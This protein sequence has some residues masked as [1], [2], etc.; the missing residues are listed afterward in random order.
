LEKFA[1][2]RYRQEVVLAVSRRLG[3]R[4]ELQVR[5]KLRSLGYRADRISVSGWTKQKEGEADMGIPADVIAYAPKD[6]GWPH[7]WVECGGSGKRLAV[8]FE[9][10]KDMPAGTIALIARM[11]GRKWK[12]DTLSGQFS[13]LADAIEGKAR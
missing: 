5:D 3:N 10:M 4:R 2:V 1:R 12:Y 9:A 7:L 8:T 13:T 11:V 6:S